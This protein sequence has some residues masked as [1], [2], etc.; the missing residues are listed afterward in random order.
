MKSPFLIFFVGILLAACTENPVPKPRAYPR[1]HYPENEGY[2]EY[3]PSDCPYSFQ[4]PSYLSV[5]KKEQFFDED[6]SDECW[7]NITCSQLDAT[8]YLSYKELGQGQSLL[9][10]ME[11]AYELT[12]KHTQKA[13]FIQPVE[14][15][16]GQGAVGLIYYVGGD[17]ASNIQFFLTDTMSHFVRGA[18]Y[19]YARPNVDSLK[20]VVEFMVND[21]QHVM[22]TWQWN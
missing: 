10:L 3:A 22:D 11:E 7:A 14:V 12:Y 21:I 17:A 18:L 20:P 8:I 15:D 1:V 4:V 5:E 19:F 2:Y 16:N 13:D 6:I 9:H